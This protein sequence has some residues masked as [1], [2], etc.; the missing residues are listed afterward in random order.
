MEARKAMHAKRLQD[1]LS[2][3]PSL[4]SDDVNVFS[5]EFETWQERTL[6]SLSELFQKDGGYTRRFTVLRFWHARVSI[7]R[8]HTW[9]V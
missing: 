1:A 2:Q 3:I 6:Q 5:S 8:G 4:L 9:T 7:G